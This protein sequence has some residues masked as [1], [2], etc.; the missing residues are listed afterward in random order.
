MSLDLDALKIFLRVAE[1]GSFTRAGEQLRLPKARV[2]RRVRS[3]EA[4]LGCTLFQRSTRL[5]R[6]SADGEQLLERARALVG[7]ADELGAMFQSGRA[8]RGPVRVDLPINVARDL[9]M[10]RLPELIARHPGLELFISTTD[11]RVDALREGFDCVLRVGPVGAAALTGRR[12]GLL[13]M[14]NCASPSYLRKYGVPLRLE[15]LDRHFVVHYAARLGAE[16]PAFEYPFEGG[17]RDWPMR[18][19]VTVNAV[20]AYVAACVAGL[21]II[22]VPRTGLL[23]TV[24]AGA[25]VEVLPELTCAPL[26]LTLLHTH[27]RRVPRRVRAVMTWLIEVVSP[28]LQALER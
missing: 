23:S 5:V 24:A 10:P 9:I 18:S 25:M 1:L 16:A 15:E 3:L 13:Q 19:L 2:S 20:D 4:E 21:G 28:H 7:E 17:H 11:R 26:P 22:Q 6:L 27:G 12:L 14:M 8:L